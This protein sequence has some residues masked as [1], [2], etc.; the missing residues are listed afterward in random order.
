MLLIKE[1]E[2]FLPANEGAVLAGT[3]MDLGYFAAVE[4]LGDGDSPKVDFSRKLPADFISLISVKALWM[5]PAAAGNM[6][7]QLRARYCA[8]GQM[9]TTH[10]DAPALGVT[11]TV[12]AW[13][14]NLSEP[15]NPLTLTDLAVGDFFGVQFY[16]EGSDALDTLNDVVDFLGLL[17]TYRARASKEGW[18]P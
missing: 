7:W 8:A 4:G 5:S 2:L 12:G 18:P 17:F 9:Y 1:Q 6:Y 3:P 14:F 11:A 10:S 15:A 13:L 16:R